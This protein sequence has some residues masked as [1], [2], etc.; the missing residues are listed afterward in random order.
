MARNVMWNMLGAV[1]PLLM[2][3]WAIPFLIRG[4]GTERFGVL[5]ILWMG[6]GYFT[7]F[8]LGIGRALTKLVAERLGDRRE[9][10]LPALIRTGMR[11]MYGLGVIAAL[12]VAAIT[13]VL[14]N[15]VLNVPQSLVGET[16]LSFWILAATLPFVIS[17]AGFVGVLQ[18]HA[19]FS[20]INAV[21]IPLGIMNFLA[22]ALALTITPSLAVTTLSL[23]AARV[24]AWLAYRGLCTR[25][26]GTPATQ[27]KMTRNATQELLSFGAWITVSNVVGP[28]MVYFDRF[29]IGALLTMSAVTY[30][31]T[32][33]E[34]V[35]RLW[36]VPE[37]LVGVLFPA[38]ATALVSDLERT[39]VLLITAA[40]A[41]LIAIFL[42]LA[43]VVLFA[44]E[45]LL[46][47]L[48]AQFV[49]ESTTV[50]RWL[51]IGVFANSLARLPYIT[52]QAC[53]RPD[54][55]AKLHLAELPVYAAILW[56]LV[57]RFGIAGAA[58]AWTIRSVGDAVVLFLLAMW[59]M[60]AL[61]GV[62]LRTLKLALVSTASLGLL[63]YPQNLALKIGVAAVII[64]VGGGFGV[65]SMV[66]LRD[67]RA[68]HNT[69]G[70]S[71]LTR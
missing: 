43:L 45:I 13:P 30:Y 42:P 62:Q 19:R 66:R 6:V 23:A 68:A 16:Q 60:P 53:G 26:A 15:T 20:A 50:L 32:P 65:H 57:D 39:K 2:A 29:L 67:E 52:L 51:A 61:S 54:L 4:L 10:E 33:Y 1:L 55:T 17:T 41:L 44:P 63:V 58:A 5:A 21:R 27:V 70:S 12:A 7:L 8:D 22:P 3:L 59:E 36:L 24:L 9:E 47:W 18:A 56:V 35:T 48:N 49:E 31:T 46:F 71:A 11:L 40:R 69:G 64:V 38:L 28:F 14:V 25:Y 34:I 37:A